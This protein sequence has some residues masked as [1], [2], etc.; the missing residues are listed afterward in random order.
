VLSLLLLATVPSYDGVN[1][2][3]TRYST[4]FLATISTDKLSLDPFLQSIFL[5]EYYE[6]V[7]W[8]KI[9]TQSLAIY[10]L[11]I[12]RVGRLIADQTIGACFVTAAI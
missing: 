2:I 6:S 5:Q 1:V 11:D 12:C 8:L 10:E 9:Y 4:A 3:S 7:I